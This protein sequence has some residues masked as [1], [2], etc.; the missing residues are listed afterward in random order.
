MTPQPDDT[1]TL[2]RDAVVELLRQAQVGAA[3]EGWL[4][5]TTTLGHSSPGSSLD[6][7]ARPEPGT[8]EAFVRDFVAWTSHHPSKSPGCEERL[9]EFG[10]AEACRRMARWSEAVSA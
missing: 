7:G 2:P 9:R 10:V 1:V 3:L 4:A 5:V 8:P 6:Y